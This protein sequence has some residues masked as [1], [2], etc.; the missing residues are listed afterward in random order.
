MEGSSARRLRGAALRVTT[1][2]PDGPRVHADCWP[3]GPRSTHTRPDG[4][5][6]PNASRSFHIN[7]T[8]P[9]SGNSSLLLFF[10]PPLLFHF[11]SKSLIDRAVARYFLSSTYPLFGNPG[12]FQATNYSHLRLNHILKSLLKYIPSPQAC[13]DSTL[14]SPLSLPR[15]PSLFPRLAMEVMVPTVIV[16]TRT[17]LVPVESPPVFPPRLQVF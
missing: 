6:T 3:L 7:L 10:H 14:P 2:A 15:W 16:A 1:K 8:R 13:L 9:P 12:R 5:T 4:Q 11:V 17:L